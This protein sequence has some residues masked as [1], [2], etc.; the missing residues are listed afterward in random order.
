M[1]AIQIALAIGADDADGYSLLR[2]RQVPQRQQCRFVRPMQI[3]EDQQEGPSRRDNAEQL[4]DGL[5]QAI[6]L[7]FNTH[8]RRDPQVG[9]TAQ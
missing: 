5:E 1:A 9:P 3:L 8:R 2:A 6:P 7:G 4:A